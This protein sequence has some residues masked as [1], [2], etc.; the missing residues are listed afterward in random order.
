MRAA[1]A[2]AQDAAVEECTSTRSHAA[3]PAAK[4]SIT[5]C[6]RRASSSDG[7]AIS[8]PPAENENG[9]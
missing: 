1:A 8:C 7:S 6:P 2:A 4:A 3:S 9:R 5:L